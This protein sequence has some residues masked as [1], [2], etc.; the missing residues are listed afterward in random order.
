VVAVKYDDISDAF[1][2]VGS[3]P[4][5]THNAYISRDTG[6]IYW[7]SELAPLDE[8]VP[9]DLDTSGSYLLVPHK[10]ELNLGR[11]LALRF[12]ASELPAH[13]DRI[14]GFFRHKGAYARFKDLLDSEGAL[15]RWY[16]YEADA[17]EKALRDWCADNDIQLIASSETSAA[18]SG[19]APTGQPEGRRE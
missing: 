9:D 7:T 10:T 15:E 11:N 4:P 2:F 17:T 14:V 1:E 12:A 8:E 19:N 16:K 3:A 13:Y 18:Q 6:H 5:C